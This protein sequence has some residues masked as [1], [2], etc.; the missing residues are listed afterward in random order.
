[1]ND[2]ERAM[3]IRAFQEI[4]RNDTTR[5]EHHQPRRW[6][7]ASPEEKGGTRWLEPNEIARRALR[8]LSAT[9]PDSW[10]ETKARAALRVS[11]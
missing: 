4:V 10:D 3:V 1:M 2:D 11:Q 8:A 6:D 9:V 5:Y 7:G